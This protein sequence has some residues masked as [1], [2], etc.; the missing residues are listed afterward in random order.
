MTVQI[1]IPK[2]ED[3]VINPL[4]NIL[5][6]CCENNNYRDVEKEIERVIAT[7]EHEHLI[8]KRIRCH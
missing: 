4:N 7:L 5:M 3:K 8:N 1:N 2:L 6:L